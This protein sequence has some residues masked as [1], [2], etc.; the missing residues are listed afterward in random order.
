MKETI[1]RQEP[2]SGQQT[3]GMQS[4]AKDSVIMQKKKHPSIAISAEQ[5]QTETQKISSIT[6]AARKQ[7]AAIS[8]PALQMQQRQH[9]MPA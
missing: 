3:S 5:L 4:S 9:A 8:D 2:V 7:S 6:P 1:A